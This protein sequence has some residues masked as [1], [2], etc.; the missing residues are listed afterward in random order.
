MTKEIN[1]TKARRTSPRLAA[2]GAILGV[3]LTTSGLRAQGPSPS[4]S[5]ATLN[6]T[7]MN[8]GTGTIGGFSVA[9][10]GEAHL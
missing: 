4:C 8:S 7:Y 3:L 10:G 9:M 6:G 1:M 5:L 2:M